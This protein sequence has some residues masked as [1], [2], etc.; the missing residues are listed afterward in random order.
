MELSAAVIRTGMQMGL[1]L[2]WIRNVST[3]GSSLPLSLPYW[4]PL[5]QLLSALDFYCVAAVNK[6]AG[7]AYFTGPSLD[8][9]GKGVL[10]TN[11]AEHYNYLV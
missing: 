9:P 11:Q 5:H 6:K 7:S 10:G 1:W 3:V 8:I 4:L 2:T